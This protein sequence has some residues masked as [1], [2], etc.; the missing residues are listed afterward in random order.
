MVQATTEWPAERKFS[1]LSSRCSALTWT[2]RV[3]TILASCGCGL[4]LVSRSWEV[5]SFRM[6]WPPSRSELLT[7]LFGLS[8]R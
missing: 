3:D 6:S 7:F 8:K 1:S 4:T 5:I 2:S